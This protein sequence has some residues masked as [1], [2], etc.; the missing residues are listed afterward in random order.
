[1]LH[2]CELEYEDGIRSMID[3]HYRKASTKLKSSLERATNEGLLLHR[4]RSMFAYIEVLVL[5]G[6]VE[7]A[8]R[9]MRSTIQE[10]DRMFAGPDRIFH[11]LTLSSAAR[12]YF[13]HL[14]DTNRAVPALRA[15]A[16]ILK[17]CDVSEIIP[18]FA[19]IFFRLHDC[20]MTC[21]LLE[22]AVEAAEDAIVFCKRQLGVS[23]SSV[24]FAYFLLLSTLR[25][26]GCNE[27]ATFFQ[28]LVAEFEQYCDTIKSDRAD[29]IELLVTHGKHRERKFGLELKRAFRNRQ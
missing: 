14:Q 28:Q 3:G 24:P 6:Q 9:L 19:E 17:N 13:L 11:A 4:M 10:S 5:S 7:K 1:M 20:L 25:Q 27:N 12:H 15:A 16:T 22:E 26:L 8:E 2:M 23:D 21:G 18:E 29:L